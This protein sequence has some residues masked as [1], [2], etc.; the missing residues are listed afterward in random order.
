[1]C[2]WAAVQLHVDEGEEPWHAVHGTMPNF[3]E[4][5]HTVKRADMWA[6]AVALHK[7]DAPA[8]LSIDTLWSVC[9][10]QAAECA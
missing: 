5:Q 2:G 6:L 4:V 9:K 7:L 1:M 8:V 10:L 3:V